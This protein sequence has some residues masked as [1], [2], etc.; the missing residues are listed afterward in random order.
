M[1]QLRAA[2]LSAGSWAAA[3]HIPA[4]A[5]HPDVELTVV[6]RRE[7]HLAQRMA[8]DFG[9]SRWTADESAAL[10]DVDIVIAAGPP[11]THRTQVVEALRR[12]CHVLCEKPFALTE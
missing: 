12:G 9:F 5:K 11:A 8:Q 3:C 1:P 7:P 4:L 2:V 6:H 10:D